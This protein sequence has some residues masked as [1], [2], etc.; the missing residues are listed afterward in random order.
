MKKISIIISIF[1]FLLFSAYANAQMQTSIDG[2]NISSFPDFPA[3]G[4]NVSISI[5]SYLIDLDSASIVWMVNEKTKAHGVGM[6]EF[7]V[8]AP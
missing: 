3:E 7:Q 2:V 8:P 6:K 1:T 5:E 4:T